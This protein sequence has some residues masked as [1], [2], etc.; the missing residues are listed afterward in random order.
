MTMWAGKKLLKK[1]F[2]FL[3]SSL[4][5][6]FAILKMSIILTVILIKLDTFLVKKHLVSFEE[7]TIRRKPRQNHIKIMANSGSHA[8][9]VI[10]FI[11]IKKK[12]KAME[13]KFKYYY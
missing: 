11:S 4:S 2:T 12:Q 3:L 8:P 5:T 1:N 10:K 7:L 13:N 9:V 6:E